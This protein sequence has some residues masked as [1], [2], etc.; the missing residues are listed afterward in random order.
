MQLLQLFNT[1]DDASATVYTHDAGAMDNT[2]MTQLLQL[3]SARDSAAT[4][5]LMMQLQ[6]LAR[7][8]CICNCQ[9]PNVASATVDTHN[10]AATFNTLDSAATANT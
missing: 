7:T 8:R 9:L 3:V 6:L 5:T 10:A 1:R 2:H 4:V